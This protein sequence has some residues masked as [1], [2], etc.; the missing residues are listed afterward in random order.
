MT[1][2]T[3]AGRVTQAARTVLPTKFGRFPAIGFFVNH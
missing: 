1:A 3:V 2:E